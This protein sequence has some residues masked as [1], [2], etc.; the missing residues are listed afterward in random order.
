MVA[1]PEIAFSVFFGSSYC[2]QPHFFSTRNSLPS[3]W[4]SSVPGIF[5]HCF[6]ILVEGLSLRHAFKLFT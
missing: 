3:C 5:S 4:Y 2:Q 1:N 6:Y